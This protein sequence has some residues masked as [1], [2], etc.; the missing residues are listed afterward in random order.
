M[1]ARVRLDHV[2]VAVCDL[3][4]ALETFQALGLRCEAVED[5]PSEHVRTAFLSAGEVAV[6]LLQPT[7]DLSTVA[8]FLASR[9]EGVHHVALRIPD[10]RAAL[11]AAAAAGLSVVPPGPRPGA[12]GRRVAFLH[13]KDTFGVL[14]ELVEAP[15]GR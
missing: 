13:P 14:V 2:A 3:K 5:V 15:E 6:E 4:R 7:S 1:T 8:R 11:E 12:R 10:L 9:G